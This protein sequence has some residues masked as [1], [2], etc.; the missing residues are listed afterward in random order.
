MKP[1][2]VTM[3]VYGFDQET[4]FKALLDARVDTFCDIRM[5]RGMRGTRYVF[6]N[7]SRLQNRLGEMGIRYLY[8]KSL[9]P[10][11]KIRE[12][13]KQEDEKLGIA[14]RTRKALGPSFIEAYEKHCL[15][16]FNSAEFI[17]QLGQDTQVISLFCVERDPEA[18]HRSV[19][20]KCLAQ[21]LDLQVEHIKP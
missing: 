5:R 3:G 13:Q 4:F 8:L 14:K 11:Q 10:D 19:A 7:S 9:A 17:E 15:S 1:K 18:C 2:I 6:V 16:T 12:M 21:E 20:A